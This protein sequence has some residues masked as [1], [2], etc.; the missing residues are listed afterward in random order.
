MPPVA[1]LVGGALGAIGTAQTAYNTAN[2][3]TGGALGQGIGGIIGG[4]RGNQDPAQA[5]AANERAKAEAQR[6]AY[7]EMMKN[8][9]GQFQTGENQFLQEANQAPPEFQAAQDALKN[10]TAEGYGQ[11]KTGLAQQGVRGGQAATQLRR[12]AGDLQQQLDQMAFQEAQGRQQAKLGYF[13]NKAQTGQRGTLGNQPPP[14][15][16]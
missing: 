16:R 9:Q 7:D 15:L 6:Q 12:G 5:M 4:N 13:G 14:V 11:L 10:K 8:A 2:S 1:G 3:L